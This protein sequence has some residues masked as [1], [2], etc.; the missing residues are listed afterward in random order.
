M[1]IQDRSSREEPRS[2][3]RTGQVTALRHCVP[4]NISATA[5]F[6]QQQQV[7]VGQEPCDHPNPC[8]LKKYPSCKLTLFLT[9]NP[10]KTLQL[11]VNSEAAPSGSKQAPRRAEPYPIVLV[12]FQPLSRTSWCPAVPVLSE[13]EL[14]WDLTP[15]GA[16]ANIDK[17]RMLA[18]DLQHA[19]AVYC[20]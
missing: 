20:C 12:L 2:L 15:G 6:T 4:R 19:S 13:P 11:S 1:G 16:T 5:A 14:I 3:A 7:D 17:R 9:Q 18:R 8:H 10:K